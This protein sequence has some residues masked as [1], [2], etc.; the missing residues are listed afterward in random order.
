MKLSILGKFIDKTFNIYRRK[1]RW[2]WFLFLAALFIVFI[3]L[4]FTNILVRKIAADE[5]ERVKLWADAI[6]HKVSLVNYTNSFFE[7]VREEERKKVK[8]WAETNKK[9]ISAS[10]NE[11]LTFYLRIISDNTTIPVILTD[12]NNRIINAVNVN[13]KKDTVEFLQ[14]KLLKEFSVFEPI[15]MY[16]QYIYYKE[17][18]VYS[19]LRNVLDDLIKSFF[20][21]IVNNSASVPVIITDSTKTHVI[22]Y[23]NV[24]STA[25]RNPVLLK[26][27]LREMEGQNEAVVIEILNYGKQYIFY[28]NSFLLIQLKYYPYIQFLIIGLFIIIAYVLFSIARGSEQNQ[29]WVGMAKETAHQIGT[30]LTSLM[31]WMEIL[32]SRGVDG[33][34]TNEMQKDINR[35]ENITERFSKIG[36]PPV[37]RME[38]L[39]SV[40]SDTVNYLK[41]RTSSK[42]AF[43]V[44]S[45]NSEIILPLN[46][47]LFEWVVENLCKNSI[48]AMNGEGQIEIKISQDGPASPQVTIDISDTGKGLPKSNFKNIFHPGFTSK[49]RGWG[50]GLSLSK[51]II[52]EYHKGK[53]YVKSSTIGKGTTIRIVLRK[54]NKRLKNS[55]LD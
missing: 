7:R 29:V 35:L 46:K 55:K 17:S 1:R 41:N 28:K 12:K 48:D 13:F 53:I 18:K 19:D 52:E 49:K 23:G 42:V 34:L 39:I 36:S 40:I 11:D 20:T 10:L 54:D 26:K 6:Q 47:H 33:E 9:I 50:L 8:L 3:S 44:V 45:L 25:I 27:T 51:R 22:A 14:G 5:R 16:G 24:D 43:K 31:A 15:S 21:E 37:I 32:K 38:N 4:W 2:K 30:P